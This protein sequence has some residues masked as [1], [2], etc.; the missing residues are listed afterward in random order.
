MQN[1]MQIMDPT[2]HTTVKWNPNDD[3]DVAVAEATFNQMTAKGYSAFRVTR[4]G[5]KSE[6]L[7]AFD[8]DAK[9]MILV[10]Q[11]QGG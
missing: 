11:L 8:P 1:E 7:R 6:R 9:A 10:P 2:G 5:G 4:L 3:D